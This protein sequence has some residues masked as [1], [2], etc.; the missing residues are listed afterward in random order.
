LAEE[1][2]Q[3]VEA[4]ASKAFHF[5]K[6]AAEQNDARALN[7]LACCYESAIGVQAD[8]AKSLALFR[9]AARQRET[10]SF[11]NIALNYQNGR[12]ST[13]NPAMTYSLYSISTRLGHDQPFAQLPPIAVD[14]VRFC[15][16][17]FFF[18]TLRIT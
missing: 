10:C 13:R 2:G 7:S 12:S 5:Y 1:I 9:R 8:H 16:F 17:S 14:Q 4:N 18:L 11:Y 3:G 6:L 15:G